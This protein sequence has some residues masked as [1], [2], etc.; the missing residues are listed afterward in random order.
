MLNIGKVRFIALLAGL[1]GF[2]PAEA[3]VPIKGQV[4]IGGG[5]LKGATVRLWAASAEAPA[6]LAEAK[7]DADRHFALAAADA[8]AGAILYIVANGGEPAGKGGGNNP[9]IALLTVLGAA[10]PEKVTINELTTVA[11]AFTAARFIKG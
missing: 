1:L 4:E 6:R 7:S 3:A 10:P 9:A 5:T 2:A 11:S 8:P